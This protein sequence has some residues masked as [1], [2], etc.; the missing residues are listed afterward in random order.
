[1][2]KERIGAKTG[3]HPDTICILFS[4]TRLGED[5]V[6]RNLGLQQVPS[7]HQ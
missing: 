4:G 5:G 2:V 7:R 3:D 1:M 6:L